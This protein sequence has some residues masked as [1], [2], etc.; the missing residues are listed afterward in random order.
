M[1]LSVVFVAYRNQFLSGMS[2]QKF[3]LAAIQKVRQYITSALMLPDS[4]RQPPSIKTYEEIDELPEPDSLDALGDLFR[5]ASP[6]DEEPSPSVSGGRWQVSA[7]NPAAALLKLPGL[8]LKRD[9]RLV[10]Y[11]YRAE[12]SGRGLVWAVPENWSTTAMLEK[13]IADFSADYHTPPK[14]EGA[15]EDC[16]E[17]IEGDGSVVSYLVASILKR[18]FREFGTLGSQ[19][20]WG[21]HRLIDAIPDKLQPYIQEELPPDFAPKVRILQDGRAA[22]EFFSCRVKSPVAICRHVDQYNPGSYVSKSSDRAIAI[23]TK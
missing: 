23:P 2:I 21:N 7:V 15:L 10:S 19:V 6:V 4:E 1:N 9:F 16:M 3:P 18:E 14:P 17:A 5:F 20:R 11:F 8:W 22:V 13:A 12:N